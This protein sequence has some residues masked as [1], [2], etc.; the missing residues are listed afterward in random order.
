MAALKI[1][2]ISTDLA[3]SAPAPAEALSLFEQANKHIKML[4]RNKVPDFAELLV[5]QSQY[6]SVSV[7]LVAPHAVARI[8]L[9]RESISI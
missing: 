3:L 7:T 1:A 5:K 4:M 6:L 2:A 8:I 9:A